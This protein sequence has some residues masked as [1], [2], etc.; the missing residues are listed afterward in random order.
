MN[1]VGIIYIAI[2]RING[3]S[4]IGKSCKSLKKR[5]SF[6]YSSAKI[7]N[8]HFAKALRK[9]KKSDWEWKI[10]YDEVPVNR[11]NKM[12]Q[13]SISNYDTY[14]SGYNSTLG[15]DGT[16]GYKLSEETKRK[17]A[18]S[19]IGKIQSASQRKK[20][21]DANAGSNNHFYGKKHSD[22]TR[23]KMS[24]CSKRL[25]GL[26]NPN[27]KIF[28]VQNEKGIVTE[29]ETRK[30]LMI[31]CTKNKIPFYSFIKHKRNKGFLLLN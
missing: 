27:S 17:I 29:C 13:W 24:E 20:N 26:D 25:S 4:Y 3:K 10:L 19:K 8:F 7:N 5:I 31:F 23:A 21:S 1:E 12:E 11:L 28:R 30:G 9:Y 14:A 22:E 18:L 2:C 15:G 16:F 6:H